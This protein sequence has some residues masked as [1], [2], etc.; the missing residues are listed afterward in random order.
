MGKRD[1]RM[2]KF[3][4]LVFILIAFTTYSQDPIQTIAKNYFRTHPFDSKFSTFILNLQ[5]DPWFTI[6]EIS[7]GP[8]KILIPFAI[9]HQN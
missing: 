2:K 1:I 4:G 3:A 5:K 6:E 9:L 8:I 7:R